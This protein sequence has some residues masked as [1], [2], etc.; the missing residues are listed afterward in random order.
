MN[1]AYP[2]SQCCHKIQQSDERIQYSR[3]LLCIVLH[4]S[5]CLIPSTIIILLE[6]NIYCVFE[7]HLC[8]LT[9]WLFLRWNGSVFIYLWMLLSLLS[10][11][12]VHGKVKTRKAIFWMNELLYLENK[13]K[14]RKSLIWSRLV[15]IRTIVSHKSYFH[16]LCI[17]QPCSFV[18]LPYNSTFFERI[19]ICCHSC[20]HSLLVALCYMTEF[21]SG[22]GCQYMYCVC[23]I[24]RQS[25]LMEYSIYTD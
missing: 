23:H 15:C 16:V 5:I 19:I 1:E 13:V 2:P 9:P 25:Q 18:I 3:L 14:G 6:S 11:K 21:S 7:Q 8:W 17:S 12:K 4:T 20:S 24:S 10:H 22:Y